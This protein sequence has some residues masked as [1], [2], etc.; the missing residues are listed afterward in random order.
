[1]AT[2][3]DDAQPDAHILI[4]DD[5]APIRELVATAL[6]FIGFR[7][8]TATTGR[9]ALR[10]IAADPPDL[11]VLDVNLPDI[12]GFEVCRRLR[13]HGEQIPV[14]F[15]TARDEDE[16]LRAGF[17]RGADDY[18]TKPFSFEELVLR[19][20]A[21][22]RR[23][24]RQPPAPARLV[25]GELVLDDAAHRVWRGQV[26]VTLTPTEF[27]LLRYLMQ[28]SGR[29]VSKDQILEHVWAFDFSGESTV[30]ETY[31]SYLRRKLDDR[32]GRLIQTVR[33][34]GYTLRAP[35]TLAHAS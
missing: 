12:D 13:D 4:V 20:R 32:P 34:F 19:I 35:D 11:I 8:E 18:L 27:R 21:I 30:V 31:V 23:S 15:L 24:R 6:G 33:G 25:C 16:D 10:T 5:E 9:D 7:V 29:V 22:L 2:T 26:E 28:N 3:N 14:I 17:A 1:M